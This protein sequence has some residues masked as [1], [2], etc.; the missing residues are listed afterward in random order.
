MGRIVDL[1]MSSLAGLVSRMQQAAGGDFERQLSVFME[2]IGMEFL[3]IV[4]DEIIRRQVVD[5]R[6]L[7][8]SFQPGD[9][10]G[11]WEMDDGGLTLV[12]GT[13]VEY[14]AHVN[15]GHWTNPKGVETRFV[16]GHWQGDRFIYNPGAKTGM[17]LKQKWVEGKHY[18]ESAL[19]ILEKMFPQLLDAML[20]DWIDQYFA[21]F[22]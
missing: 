13:N 2:G 18:W 21:G 15:D 16:P 7:L 20:Q 3:R 5:S 10:A 17:V 1:D 22:V 19:R 4:G 14:A 6:L 12:I 9:E 8:T 11:V